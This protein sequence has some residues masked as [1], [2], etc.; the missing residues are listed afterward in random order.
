MD[1]ETRERIRINNEK[2]IIRES[3]GGFHSPL[4]SAVRHM[5]YAAWSGRYEC[6]RIYS[7]RREYLDFYSVIYVLEGQL[8]VEYEGKI[9]Q[10]RQNEAVLL[11][12]HKPH[13]YRAVSD[14]IDKWEMLF[15]GNESE[16]WYEMVT[17]DGDYLFKAAGRLQRTLTTLMEELNSSYP[18][19]H[20]ISLLIH[21][22]F[23]NMIDQKAVTLSPPIEEAILYMNSHYGDSIQISEIADHV[24]LSRFYFSRLFRKETGR[25]PNEYLADIRISAAKEMLTERILSITE[26][27]ELCGFTNTSHFTR[28]FREKTGQT[29]AAFRSSFNLKGI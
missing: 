8:E 12:F 9:L 21:T 22:M 14:R 5:F 16:A 13:A 18:Q 1:Q 10:V 2:G 11:D 29:P 17:G 15:K 27:A 19:D 25:S 24:S 28:F 23:C 6:N 7:V 3:G 26:I 20:T 4:E